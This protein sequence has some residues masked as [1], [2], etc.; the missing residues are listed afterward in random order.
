MV[1]PPLSTTDQVIVPKLLPLTCNWALVPTAK[2]AF[3]GL[4]MTVAVTGGPGGL[5]PP[6]PPPPL[7]ASPQGSSKPRDKM[8][9]RGWRK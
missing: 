1:P 9:R 5:S 8:R 2:L 4:T 7:Q 6:P 3:S